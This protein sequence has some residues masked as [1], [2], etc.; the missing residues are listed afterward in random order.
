MLHTTAT[1]NCNCL[2]HAASGG[3]GGSVAATAV[4][5]QGLLHFCLQEGGGSGS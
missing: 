5:L 1:Y 2:N 3:E 4:P